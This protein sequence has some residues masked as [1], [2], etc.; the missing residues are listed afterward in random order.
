[1]EKYRIKTTDRELQVIGIGY[2]I[3]GL[4][5]DFVRKYADGRI[6]LSVTHKLGTKVFTNKFDFSPRMLEL[7]EENNN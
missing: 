3:N 1:M 7:V 4:E 5:G 2:N 6:C